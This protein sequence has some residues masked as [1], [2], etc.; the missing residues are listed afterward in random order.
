MKRRDFIASSVAAFATPALSGVADRDIGLRE[1][2]P[3]GLDVST[4][5]KPSQTRA[6]LEL[7]RKH[8]SVVVPEFGLKPQHAYPDGQNGCQKDNSVQLPPEW[9]DADKAQEFAKQ[10]GLGFHAHTLYWPKHNW[11]ACFMV[12]R[13]TQRAFIR[14]FAEQIAGSKFCDVLNEIFW[15]DEGQDGNGK[16]FALFDAGEDFTEFDVWSQVLSSDMLPISGKQ[17]LDFLVFI[18][19]TLRDDLAGLNS[20]HTRL[21]IN[22]DQLT[23]P[24]KGPIIKRNAMLGFLDYMEGQ[25]ARL[26][27]VGLQGHIL[28]DIGVD[29]DGTK[30]FIQD[31]GRKNYEVHFSELDYDNTMPYPLDPASDNEHAKTLGGLLSACLPESNVKRVGF[32]GLVDTEHHLNRDNEKA[33]PALF[34]TPSNPKPVFS[35]VAE[36]L[37]AQTAR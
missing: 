27:G 24:G 35:A 23:W 31:L 10:H 21:L 37:E 32:W 22:E 14:A 1:L 20:A 30:G 4:F 25:G 6:S 16:P 13:D 15:K 17:R 33:R 28:A 5:H 12:S 8:C 7:I 26:D 29:A 19:Q 3:K 11:P 34:E 2:A 9:R 18:V 36:I